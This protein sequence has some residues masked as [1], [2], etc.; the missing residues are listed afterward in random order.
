MKI[1]SIAILTFVLLMANQTYSQ[2]TITGMEPQKAFKS[3][4]S[5]Y[6]SAEVA[7]S[8]WAE[9]ADQYSGP[10]RFYHTLAHLDNFYAQLLKCKN[11][12][13][14]WQSAVIAM[15]YHDVIYHTPDRKDEE[16]S[17]ELAVLRLGK[18]PKFPKDKID[19]INTLILATKAHGESTDNDTNLFNDGDMTILGL[20]RSVYQ[21]YVKDVRSE[22]NNVPGFDAGRKKVLQYFLDMKRI[23]K[24]DFFNKLYEA[25]ARENIRWEISTL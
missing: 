11:D 13:N 25:S 5:E 21:Q 16:R 6:A 8:L 19:R 3:I 15:V 4:I 20:E 23:F 2:Q 9:I 14:D 1:L 22:Y 12:L 7:D 17:A 10:K 18:I 24:S